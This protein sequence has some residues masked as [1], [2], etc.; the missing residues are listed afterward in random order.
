ME[1]IPGG[2]QGHN[3]Y[4]YNGHCYATNSVNRHGVRYLRCN[5]PFCTVRAVVDNNIIR[6]NN[7]RFHTH[8][9]RTS[10]IEDLRFRAVLRRRSANID[11]VTR[12]SLNEIYEEE[13]E[14]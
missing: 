11:D 9:V 10:D 7:A 13:S 2:R 14:R 12:T 6:I 4:V 5:H 1:I 3:V 8:G